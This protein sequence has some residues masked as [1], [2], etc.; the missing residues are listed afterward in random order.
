MQPQE[1]HHATERQLRQPPQ[2]PKLKYAAENAWYT[3]T[4]SCSKSW[5][6]MTS[7]RAVQ[8]FGFKNAKGLTKGGFGDLEL[9][10]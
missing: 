9:L 3:E 10:E 1:V 7:A 8:A 5:A 6:A 2:F 4:R